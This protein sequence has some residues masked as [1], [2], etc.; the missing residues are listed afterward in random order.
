[1]RHHIG[2]LA[3]L[4]ES[5]RM[6]PD[7]GS[8]PAALG[9][10][11]MEAF[12]HRLAFLAA[13]GTISI[14]ARIRACREV[15]AVLTRIRAAGLTRPGAVAAGLGE[16]FTLD[17]GRHPGQARTRRHR[18]RVCRRRSCESSALTWTR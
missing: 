12:L 4:S 13:D 9:R 18:S 3:R 1:M 7:R 14:D 2:A 8:V 17:H 5:L 10:A 15:R 11:D 6:R 16:D